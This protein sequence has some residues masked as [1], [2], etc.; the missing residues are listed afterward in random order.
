MTRA[1]EQSAEGFNTEGKKKARDMTDG[2]VGSSA[3]F[4]ER[5][6]ATE[7]RDEPRAFPR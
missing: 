7:D 2:D 3:W 4:G 6:G 1:G 5:T